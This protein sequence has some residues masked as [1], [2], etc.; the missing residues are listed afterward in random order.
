MLRPLPGVPLDTSFMARLFVFFVCLSIYLFSCLLAWLLVSSFV[1]S[2]LCSVVRSFFYS[3]SSSSVS[4]ASSFIRVII[5]LPGCFAAPTTNN[6]V[7]HCS[8]STRLAANFEPLLQ[9][10]V[11][12]CLNVVVA[13][14]THLS[15]LV[16]AVLLTSWRPSKC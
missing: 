14:K 11:A 2:L 8:A 13:F 4:L 15:R 7:V 12:K 3:S 9:H 5:K 6:A 1:R 10:D 16:A